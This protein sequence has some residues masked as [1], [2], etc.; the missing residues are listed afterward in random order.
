MHPTIFSRVHFPIRTGALSQA[1]SLYLQWI[2][3]FL[4]LLYLSFSLNFSF[5]SFWFVLSRVKQS[6]ECNAPYVQ[7]CLLSYVLKHAHIYPK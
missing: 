5:T 7:R 4:L 6:P 2:Q 1:E 3:A